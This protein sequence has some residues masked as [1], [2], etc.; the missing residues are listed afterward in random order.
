MGYD[1]V[2]ATSLMPHNMVKFCRVGWPFVFSTCYR[3]PGEL[4]GTCGQILLPSRVCARFPSCFL[5]L[6]FQRNESFVHRN[7]SARHPRNN[8]KCIVHQQRFRNS[9]I[10]TPHLQDEHSK[11]RWEEKECHNH[12]PSQAS[13]F[14]VQARLVHRDIGI[15]NISVAHVLLHTFP[16][17]NK[18]AGLSGIR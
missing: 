14:G 4:L 7:K 18:R 1:A 15:F 8:R 13:E 16:M 10:R 9:R 12:Y 6:C 11:S 3:Y 17:E 2:V 5:D